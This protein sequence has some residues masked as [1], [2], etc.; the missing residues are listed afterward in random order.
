MYSPDFSV[1]L[2]FGVS[3]KVYYLSI[4]NRKKVSLSLNQHFK[5]RIS[6][7]F[8]NHYLLPLSPLAQPLKKI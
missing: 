7:A 8:Q 5:V 3:K 6:Y 2:A 1:S 4:V